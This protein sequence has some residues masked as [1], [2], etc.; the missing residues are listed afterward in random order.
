MKMII[1]SSV[2]TM[3]MGSTMSVYENV[4]IE[5]LAPNHGMMSIVA[6]WFEIPV[7]HASNSFV[8]VIDKP[9]PNN[10][11]AMKSSIHFEEH[12]ITFIDK[13]GVVRDYMNKAELIDA[14]KSDK[15][16]PR[17]WKIPHPNASPKDEND[18][19]ATFQIFKKGI[20]LTFKDGGNP[21]IFTLKA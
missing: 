12:K 6:F 14:V 9:T 10:P 19:L 1:I 5:A 7:D 15:E 17:V 21:M 18:F 8:K 4:K 11:K 13:N 20:V 2:L 16:K 3:F